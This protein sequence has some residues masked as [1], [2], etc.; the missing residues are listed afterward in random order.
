MTDD[1]RKHAI[2]YVRVSTRNQADNGISL[3]N[4]KE[5]IKKY[6]DFYN[7]ELIEILEDHKS[8]KSLKGRT[9]AL[10]IISRIEKKEFD[11]L[12]I[13]KLDRLGR[14]VID[15]V[16]LTEL[17]A[18]HGVDLHSLE[19]KIDTSTA[20]GRFFFVT[21]ASLA[22]LERDLIS[23]RTKSALSTKRANGGKGCYNAPFG[24]M[25]KGDRW[26]DNPEE[27]KAIRIVKEMKL[28]GVKSRFIAEHMNMN[29]FRD[30]Q[31]RPYTSLLVRKLSKAD[32]TPDINRV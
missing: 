16:G 10:D 20:L 8:G 11:C 9:A 17:M 14:S 25:A 23:E 22:Q 2:G 15:L 4:Q 27:L 18:K 26:I 3:E 12:V 6:C 30:R 31:G 7:L 32:P 13:Y 29:G 1:G 28:Q 24:K 21:L 19:E 5:R